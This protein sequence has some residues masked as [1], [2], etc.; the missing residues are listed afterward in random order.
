MEGP[1]VGGKE[2]GFIFGK[3]ETGVGV[4]R[5]GGEG[6]EGKVEG[7]LRCFKVHNLI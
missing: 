3:A 6:R 1:I 5:R 7:V 4:E 2:E